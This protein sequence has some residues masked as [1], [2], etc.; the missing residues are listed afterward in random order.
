MRSAR[1]RTFFC[2]VFQP[3]VDEIYV[4]DLLPAPVHGIGHAKPLGHSPLQLFAPLRV[5]EDADAFEF[6]WLDPRFHTDWSCIVAHPTGRIRLGPCDALR[7]RRDGLQPSGITA[8]RFT[9]NTLRHI[10]SGS[11]LSLLRNS[12][13]RFGDCGNSDITCPVLKTAEG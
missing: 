8:F 4:G 9:K 12:W 2:V 10:Q 13:P 11:C 7:R 6:I 3:C 1:N 5:S